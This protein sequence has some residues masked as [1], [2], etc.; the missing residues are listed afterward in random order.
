MTEQE[1]MITISPDGS[2]VDVDAEGFTGGACKDFMKNTIEALGTVEREKK[3][4]EYYS[5]G[6]AG[7]AVRA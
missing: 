7:Q 6:S 2:K 3:K 1:V 5:T 4:P